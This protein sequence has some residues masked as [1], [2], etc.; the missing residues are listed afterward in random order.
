MRRLV[1]LAFKIAPTERKAWFEAMAAELDHVPEG[2]RWRFAAGCLLAAV[3]E[4]MVSPQFLH[5]VARGVLIGGALIWAALNLR[6]AGR[7]SI[8]D[9]FALEALGYGT[10]SLFVVG[11]LATARFGYR[12]TVSLATPLIAVLA[13]TVIF[14][15]VGSA[16][17][18][19]SDLY[20][21]LIV[22]DLLV[23]IFAVL[24]A[25]AAARHAAFRQELS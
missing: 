4:C 12:A 14:I 23:L 2:V 9:A 24:V 11:A 20:L 21:A 16:P 3:T 13:A 8:T 15:R 18:P 22:E 25:V 19:T 5:A 10:A 1:A 6:F 17:A 7:M